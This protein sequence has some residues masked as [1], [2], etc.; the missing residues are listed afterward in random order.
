MKRQ[1]FTATISL[2]TVIQLVSM[3]AMA[4]GA[5]YKF[6]ARLQRNE[7]LLLESRRRLDDHEQ[8]IRALAATS[9]RLVTILEER[10][11]RGRQN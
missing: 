5:Y 8:T 4:A 2:G 1:W 11:I 7:E 10:N 3:V 9:T 6:D